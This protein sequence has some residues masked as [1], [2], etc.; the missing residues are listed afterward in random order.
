MALPALPPSESNVR[1]TCRLL[2]FPVKTTWDETVFTPE[3]GMQ[4]E[5]GTTV[6]I[7]V[8]RGVGARVG[9]GVAV[10]GGVGVAVAVA[11]AVAVAV[12][13]AVGVGV[14][15]ASGLLPPHATS[16]M[17]S[18]QATPASSAAINL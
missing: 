2:V 8:G 12:G 14:L 1:L 17:I 7:A 16:A 13:V 11:F 10:G 18:R 6:G 5:G 4:T 15:T 3:A 9:T